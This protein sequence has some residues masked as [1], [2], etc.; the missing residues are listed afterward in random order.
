M[1]LYN[2]TNH[3]IL[4]RGRLFSGGFVMLVETVGHLMAF[5]IQWFVGLVLG[6]LFWVMVFGAAGYFLMGKKVVF[7]GAFLAL[8]IYGTMDL[9]AALGW[10]FSN[11][12]FFVPALVFLSLIFYDSFF[13]AS[14]WGP[15][16]RGV[17]TSVFFYCA[18]I[19]V[20]VFV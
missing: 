12:I 7:G 19:F 16:K 5:D 3:Y 18:L 17:A 4:W 6:N 2:T 10:G 20:N 14:S 13:G 8:Y 15:A 9:A 11:G 1:V